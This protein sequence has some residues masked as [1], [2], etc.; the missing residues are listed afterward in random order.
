MQ[1]EESD[2]EQTRNRFRLRRA[3]RFADFEL[4]VRHLRIFYRV[5]QKEVRVALI[6]KNKGNTLVIEGR[7]FIL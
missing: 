4:R 2:A 7:R 6:G 1:L 3:S 5:Y